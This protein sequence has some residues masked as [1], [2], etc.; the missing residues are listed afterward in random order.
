MIF[1]FFN[2]MQDHLPIF[3]GIVAV[4]VIFAIGADRYYTAKQKR[5]PEDYRY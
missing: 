4:V 1:E 2:R 3:V 5:N